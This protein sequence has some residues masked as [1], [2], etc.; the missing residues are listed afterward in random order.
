[1]RIAGLEGLLFGKHWNRK[2]I[3]AFQTS[4]LRRLVHHAYQ[5][6]PYYRRLFQQAGIEPHQI[7]SLKDLEKIP[8]TTRH[9]LQSLPPSDLVAR[10]LD[11]G[12]LIVHRT[13]GSSGEP[14]S[15]RRT[16]LED[17]LLQAYRLA[18]L[19]QLGMRLTDQRIAVVTRRLKSTPLYMKLGLLPYREIDCLEPHEEML[20]QLRANPPEVLRGFPGT[21]SWLARYMTDA[22]RAI[23]RPH[24]IVTDSETMTAE[25]RAGITS[26]FGA[27]VIDFYDSHEYNM[28]AW[29]CRP[30]GLYHVSDLSMIAEVV[31]DGRAA[32]PHEDGELIGT[33][34]HSWAMPLIRF[35]LGDLVTRGPHECLCAAPNSTLSHVQGRLIDRFELPNGTTVHPYKLVR[36]L[37]NENPWIQRFQIVQCEL[38][39]IHVKVVPLRNQAAATDAAER[40]RKVLSEALGNGISISVELTESI[41]ADSNGKF[42]PY[43]S[44]VSRHAL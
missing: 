41:P 38:D 35:S 37:L 30:G 3:E 21:L 11:A 39:R 42:R 5:R 1:M 33:A 29:E 15:I 7:Q 40:I 4:R 23:I 9:T 8:P 27:N 26:A 14:F 22:D 18:V 12:K 36:P 43:Y 13:S 32:E 6:V 16:A 34:V 25:M 20:R 19:L 44:M 24:L 2:Q 31:R 10:G 17:R 28:I